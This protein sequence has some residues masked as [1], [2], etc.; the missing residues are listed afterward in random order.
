[1]VD[2]TRDRVIALEVTVRQLSTNVQMLTTEVVKL[3]TLL[4]KAHGAKWAFLTLATVVGF[5][6]G[7]IVKF[8]PI[9]PA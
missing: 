2:D 3:N 9:I 6:I 4:N 8:Y 5:T 1:M 7:L